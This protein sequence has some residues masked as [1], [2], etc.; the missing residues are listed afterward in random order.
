MCERKPCAPLSER[1]LRA[2]AKV[3][4]RASWRACIVTVDWRARPP[5][6]TIGTHDTPFV[7]NLPFHLH[8]ALTIF[9]PRVPPPCFS[10]L[11][12]TGGPSLAAAVQEVVAGQDGAGFGA[13]SSGGEMSRHFDALVAGFEEDV[14]AER[15]EALLYLASYFK[16]RGQLT[17]A[18]LLCARLLDKVGAEGDE[19]R[20]IM[21]EIRALT[22]SHHNVN[23]ASSSAQHQQ[24]P[25]GA[26]TAHGC[27]ERKSE[28]DDRNDSEMDVARVEGDLSVSLNSNEQHQRL[29]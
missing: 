4:P 13:A 23:V 9:I 10:H 24:Q 3:S 11:L 29:W 19:A 1:S 20:A 6:A 7:R 17:Q 26:G 28:H 15:A 12:L 16:G 5:N 2:I 25:R 8:T 22:T 27:T 21:R 18:E 14:D